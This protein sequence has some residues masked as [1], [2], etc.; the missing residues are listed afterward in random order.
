MKTSYVALVLALNIGIDPP[1][2]IKMS[3][4]ARMECWTDPT[5]NPPKKALE[6]IGRKLQAQVKYIFISVLFLFNL[7]S[8]KV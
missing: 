8:I 4:C 7:F 5:L 3:P 6:E 2:I 1:D